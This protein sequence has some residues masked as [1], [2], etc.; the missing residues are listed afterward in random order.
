MYKIIGAD[1]QQ[2]GPVSA[3]QIRRWIA[4]NR[5]NAQTLVQPDSAADWRPLSTLAEFE[6]DLKPAPPL[7]SSPAPQPPP[8]AGVTAKASNRIAAGILGSC[9]ARWASTNSS[10]ATPARG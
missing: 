2:Y 1:G 10:W 3:D 7:V 6:A 9:S 5:V 4:E 8:A